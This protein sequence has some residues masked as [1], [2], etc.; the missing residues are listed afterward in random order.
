[1][2]PREYKVSY[3][4]NS[5]K[6]T[7]DGVNVTVTMGPFRKKTFPFV[8]IQ[9]YY[10]FE[11]G[12]YRSL[13]VTYLNEKG[14]LKKAQLFADIGDV[15]FRELVADLNNSIGGKSLNHLPEKEAF[16]VMKQA[17]P[18]KLGMI[19]AACIIV[20]LTTAFMYPGLLHYFDFG[21]ERA[22]VQQL[23]RGE[24]LGTR[25]L[26]LSG[27]P[28]EEAVEEYYT[29]TSGR[30]NSEAS[31]K[32]F[33][34]LVPPDWDYDRPIK[35]VMQ[36]EYLSE[37]EFDAILEH[38]TFTGVVRDIGYEGLD[39]DERGYFMTEYG[40]EV[41]EDAILFEVTGDQHNDT[42]MIWIWVA[43]NGFF[44]IIFAI[45]YYKQMKG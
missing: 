12:P 34:P 8:N 26:E 6:F 11:N 38:S 33:V 28:L 16:K 24:D 45:I 36:F 40:L 15:G 1:M 17:N 30:S 43:I 22:E 41:P 21:F 25:N 19:I 23:I 3:M 4:V 2:Q 39:D 10:V 9:N 44:G 29:S 27:I 37:S 14:K 20:G 42:H 13:W 32:T 35:V 31:T 18:K 7:F 5:N